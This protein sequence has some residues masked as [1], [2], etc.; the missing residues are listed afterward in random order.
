MVIYLEL[1]LRKVVIIAFY[2]PVSINIEKEGAKAPHSTT[3]KLIT[4]C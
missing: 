1:L 2:L 4:P 3:I